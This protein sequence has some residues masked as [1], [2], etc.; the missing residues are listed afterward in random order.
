LIFEIDVS[1]PDILS[2]D[3]T[4][5]AAEKNSSNLLLG[6]K[7]DEKTINVISSRWG[8]GNY[9][10]KKSK[11]G[12]ASLRVRLYCI[13]V[14]CIFK[15]LKAKIKEN[16]L[17]MDIC[18]DFTGRE[19]QIRQSLEFLLKKIGFNV[20]IQ[21]KQLPKDSLADKYAF[22]LRKDTQNKFKQYLIEIR[23]DEF[24]EFLK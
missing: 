11:N 3:Y 2:K 23:I 6:F 24:E 20:E 8:Q 10:Y 14:Y 22:L 12:K 18:R 15:K 5:V 19:D 4:I 21:F 17:C 13:A 7:F 1:G 16:F 9:K